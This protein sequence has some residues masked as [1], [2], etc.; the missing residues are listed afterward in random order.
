MSLSSKTG[1]RLARSNSFQ[2][3]RN[4]DGGAGQTSGLGC[5]GELFREGDFTPLVGLRIE[6]GGRRGGK[7]ERGIRPEAKTEIKRERREMLVSKTGWKHC[8]FSSE[9]VQ[10]RVPMAMLSRCLRELLFLLYSS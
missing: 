5:G 4:P 2:E 3:R 7:E 6:R 9:T 8:P 1:S 10:V